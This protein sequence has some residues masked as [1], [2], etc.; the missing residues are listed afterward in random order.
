LYSHLQ[1]L[2][3]INFGASNPIRWLYDAEGNKLRKITKTGAT[4][5]TIDYSNGLEYKNNALDAIYHSEGRVRPGTGIAPFTQPRYEYTLSDHLGNGRVYYTDL[6]GN[7]V[8]DPADILQDNHYYP[9][10]L[11][12]TDPR[13]NTGGVGVNLYQ[14]N[15]KELVEDNGLGWHSYGKRYYDAAIGRFPNVDPLIDTFHFVTGYN[16]AE[17]EPVAHIDLWGLQKVSFQANFTQGTY[18]ADI[19]LLGSKSG[20]TTT[21]DGRRLLGVD[22]SSDEGFSGNALNDESKLGLSG[23]TAVGGEASMVKSNDTGETTTEVKAELGPINF[24]TTTV[25]DKDGNTTTTTSYGISLGVEAGFGLLGFKVELNLDIPVDVA[26]T[27]K[28]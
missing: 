2:D 14:Y 22:Y 8:G 6:N 11:N 15:G 10:G 16:Y 5:T 20:A 21:V 17:N 9:F 24:K 28:E 3:E 23:G 25:K 1:L 13:S 7:G 12:H 26:V 18:G 4:I 19:R 27:K